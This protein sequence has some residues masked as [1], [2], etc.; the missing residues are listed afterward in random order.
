MIT[1]EEIHELLNCSKKD[2][3]V[4]GLCTINIGK[5]LNRENMR[6][7]GKV[8]VIN[9]GVEPSG[10]VDDS[11]QPAGRITISQGGNSAGFV[12]YIDV[13]F[14]AGAHCYV[15]AEVDL[16]V[17]YRY[18]YHFLKSKEKI[19]MGARQGAGIPGLKKSVI[20][21][22]IIALP[23]MDVQIKVAKILDSF[24]EVSLLLKQ[25]LAIRQDLYESCSSLFYSTQ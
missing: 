16:T 21:D 12:N 5:Q 18:L 1:P 7:E 4:G 10:Y 19:L 11:N 9:G 14:W 8:P 22:L 15:I 3:K 17:D 13:P 25:E 6:N 20:Q 2:S 24:I 23:P